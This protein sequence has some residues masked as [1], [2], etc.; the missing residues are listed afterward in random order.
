MILIEKLFFITVVS[1][2]ILAVITIPPSLDFY[3]ESNYHLIKK[4][5]VNLDDNALSI[6]NNDIAKKPISDDPS[7]TISNTIPLDVVYENLENSV[8]QITSTVIETH[9]NIIINGNP[10]EQQSSRLGSG[11]VYD[12]QGHIITNYH[13][14]SDVSTVDVSLSNGDVFTA[15]VIGTDRLNDIAVLQLTDDYSNESLT[16]VL[17]ADSSQI[18]IGDQVIAI[19]N[20]F[21][22]SNTMTT[23]IVSQT[24]RLLPNQNL[25]FS[26]SNIIQTDAAI[27]PGNSGGPLL[28]SDG[29]LIGMNTAIESKV[30]EFTGVGFAIPSNTIKKIVPVLIKKGEYDHPWIGISGITLS[31]KLAEKLQLPKNFRGALINDV[32]DNGPA[33]KAG[34][35]GALYKSN[36]EISNADIIISIDD[37]PVKRIDDIISYV[38]ENKSVGDK[39]SFKV[40]RDGKVIDIDVIL[41]KRETT[42]G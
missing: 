8:V 35:K 31:P 4:T 14:I 26:I 13:V 1:I 19:G 27:N 39:V 32:V 7:Q 38:S 36:R 11:F 15:K 30:G 29:N 5:P 16:P 6:K 33:E 37:T 24:G 20:P 10:V 34:I 17:F 21:G 28:D 22:L 18:K 41:G 12:E 9:S 40:F 3:F 2:G 23:G 25:G 42:N